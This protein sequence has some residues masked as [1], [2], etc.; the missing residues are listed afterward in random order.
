MAQD[1]DRGNGD[2]YHPFHQMPTCHNNLCGEKKVAATQ[3]TLG[4]KREAMTVLLCPTCDG[5]AV[6]LATRAS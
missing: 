2:K 1:V 6:K 3:K 4:K 5:G